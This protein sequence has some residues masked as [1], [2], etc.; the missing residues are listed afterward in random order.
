MD[1]DC[2]AF[3]RVLVEAQA[4]CPIRILGYVAISLAG[5]DAAR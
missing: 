1:G 2:A 3:E 5:A 4:R